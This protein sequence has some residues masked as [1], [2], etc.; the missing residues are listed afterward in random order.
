MVHGSSKHKQDAC[1]TCTIKSPFNI[2]SCSINACHIHRAVECQKTS[3]WVV[4]HRGDGEV[5]NGLSSEPLAPSGFIHA[6]HGAEHSYESSMSNQG[7]VDA[8][9][10]ALLCYRRRPQTEKRDTGQD[11]GDTH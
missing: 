11:R 1:N 8:R 4:K 3:M 7:L 10:S 6:I 9:C 5:P 2:I